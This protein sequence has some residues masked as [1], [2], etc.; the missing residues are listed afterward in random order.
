MQNRGFENQ[1]FSQTPLERPSDY[2]KE[3][4]NVYSKHNPSIF[5]T[6][7]KKGKNGINSF[8]KSFAS[9]NT[10]GNSFNQAFSPS[11]IRDVVSD[12]FIP[13]RSGP[14]SRNHFEVLEDFSRSPSKIEPFSEEA[15][16]QIKYKSLLEN[17]LLDFKHSDIFSKLS[18]SGSK[19]SLAS[20]TPEMKGS[21]SSSQFL[22]PKM[23]KFKTPLREEKYMT[24]NFSLSPFM[25][26]EDEGE[27]IAETLKVYRKIPKTPY[28]ILD[29]PGLVDDFYVNLLHWSQRNYLAVS[30][31]ALSLASKCRN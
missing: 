20:T 12:R 30:L 25:D 21:Y 11:P 9:A 16:H 8:K 24:T 19:A 26:L 3:S 2:S 4:M 27:S 6:P 31:L 1:N 28:K 13:I 29:A 22:K 14:S 10:F 5:A 7:D 18:K 15:Q 23:L 17:Q